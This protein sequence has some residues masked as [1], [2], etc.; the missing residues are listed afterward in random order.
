MLKGCIA[1]T[2]KRVITLRKVSA[3]WRAGEWEPHGLWSECV[4]GGGL[5]CSVLQPAPGGQGGESKKGGVL[6]EGGLSETLLC[7]LGVMGGAEWGPPALL[8]SLSHGPQSLLVHHNRQALENIE[9]KFIDTTS[10]FGHGRFQTAQ[11]KRA[12]MVS[13]SA[14]L[15]GAQTPHPI[16]P[17]AGICGTYA[18]ALIQRRG[19]QGSSPGHAVLPERK[20]GRDWREGARGWLREPRR[21]VRPCDLTLLLSLARQGPQK[22]HLEKEKPETSG[23]L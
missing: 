7:G 13:P 10:K 19:F 15:S 22:K 6:T 11:E 14:L 4:G 1:G 17:R 18:P 21:L 2:K 5:A 8:F 23:D 16:C 3:R 9:L 12:F 20:Q